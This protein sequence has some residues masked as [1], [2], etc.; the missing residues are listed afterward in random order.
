MTYQM[1]EQDW[2]ELV[3]EFLNDGRSLQEQF[4]STVKACAEF[5]QARQRARTVLEKYE[6]D[7][8]LLTMKLGIIGDVMTA[9]HK[10]AEP[11][12]SPDVTQ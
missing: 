7:C 3:K 8:T 10:K 9:V 6:R 12:L 5:Q 2:V 1:T 11:S 4:D